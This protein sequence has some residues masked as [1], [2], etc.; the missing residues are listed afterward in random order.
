V[1][2]IGRMVFQM[3]VRGGQ[4]LE[5]GG[6]VRGRRGTLEE[7]TSWVLNLNLFL[8]LRYH[9]VFEADFVVCIMAAYLSNNFHTSCLM[10]MRL[11]SLVEIRPR[12]LVL[13]TI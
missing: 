3:R 5:V 8:P 7:R 10:A 12:L 13:D 11:V 2:P 4:G 1:R 6:V 9:G